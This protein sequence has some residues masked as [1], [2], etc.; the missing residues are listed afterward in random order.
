MK[1]VGDYRVDKILKLP[2]KAA[3]DR[4]TC[5]SDRKL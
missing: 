4:N 1:H 2:M 5:L 3:P